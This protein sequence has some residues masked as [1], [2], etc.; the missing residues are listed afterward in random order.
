MTD[1]YANPFAQSNRAILTGTDFVA[2][3][4][5]PDWIIDGIVQRG[6]LYACTSLTNHGKTAG[7]ITPA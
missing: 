6:R 2:S 3:Y 4:T 7:S 5:P 1:F